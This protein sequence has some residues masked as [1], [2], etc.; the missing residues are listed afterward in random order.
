MGP[1]AP[2]S[3]VSLH[4]RDLLQQLVGCRQ[5][6]LILLEMWGSSS[7]TT[8]QHTSLR[9]TS[10]VHPGEAALFPP[11]SARRQDFPW[12]SGIPQG[13]TSF[14]TASVLPL[15]A[16]QKSRLFLILHGPRCPA[17]VATAHA[18]FHDANLLSAKNTIVLLVCILQHYK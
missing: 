13:Q 17:C 4:D 12:L 9:T 10:K 18:R 15:G 3:P 6:S 14:R 11:R 7:K 2:H 8:P 1:R 16:S 5:S